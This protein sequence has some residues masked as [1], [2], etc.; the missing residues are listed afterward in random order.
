MSVSL[1]LW[2]LWFSFVCLSLILRGMTVRRAFCV[3]TPYSVHAGIQMDC[4]DTKLLWRKYDQRVVPVLC[5]ILLRALR[6]V[7]QA[8]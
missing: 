7:C 8:A 5:V 4:E 6:A 3:A 2:L 1:F